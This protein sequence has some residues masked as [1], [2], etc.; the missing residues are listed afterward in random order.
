MIPVYWLSTY[1][2]ES[3]EKISYAYTS[4]IKAVIERLPAGWVMRID[5]KWVARTPEG[6]RAD[7]DSRNEA[8]SFLTLLVSAGN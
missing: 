2:Q 6:L 5:G 3:K 7:F 4:E 8:I 1:D